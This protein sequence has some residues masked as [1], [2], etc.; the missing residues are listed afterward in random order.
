MKLNIKKCSSPTNTYLLTC[1]GEE[2]ILGDYLVTNYPD[3]LYLQKPTLD[4]RGRTNKFSIPVNA[5]YSTCKI[6]TLHEIK[7]GLFSVES[8]DLNYIVNFKPV[9][10]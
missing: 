9:E 5:S 4:N 10:T 6:T 8:D 2:V 7:E 3:C 1:K